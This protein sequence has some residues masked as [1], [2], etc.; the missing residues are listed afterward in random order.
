MANAATIKDLDA[1][2]SFLTLGDR[3]LPANLTKPKIGIVCGSGLGGLVDIIRNKVEFPYSEIPGFVDST[4]A[5]HAGKLAFGLLGD[6]DV[7]TVCMVGRFHFYEGFALTQTTY[8]IRLMS[9]LGVETLIVTNA[10]GGLNTAFQIGDVCIIEDHINLPG[11]TGNNPLVGPNMIEFGPRFPPMSDAYCPRLRRLVYE[12][13][14]KLNI[15]K[16][17]HEGVYVFVSG[18]TYESKA[19]CRFLKSIGADVV[20]MST[21]PEVVVA[22]HCGMKV[23]GLSLVTNRAVIHRE[24]RS[25]PDAPA[26]VRPL[27]EKIASH[28]EVLEAADSRAKD[29]QTLVKYLVEMI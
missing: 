24:S 11:M 28:A 8:P 27:E 22:R 7:P 17:L 15:P 21:V 12:A 13:A 10:A 19:E 29:L 18:P 3:A 4:V 23:L 9:L 6:N 25:D 16:F 14:K 1:A 20:G 2:L 26:E 5:G